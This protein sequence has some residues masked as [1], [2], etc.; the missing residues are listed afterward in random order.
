[1]GRGR[2]IAFWKIVAKFDHIAG[3]TCCV[4]RALVRARKGPETCFCS[5]FPGVASPAAIQWTHDLP[6]SL[7]F[8]LTVATVSQTPAG[9][10]EETF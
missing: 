9:K 10:D 6:K 8:L 5:F 7:P 4:G 1:M 2:R 3:I